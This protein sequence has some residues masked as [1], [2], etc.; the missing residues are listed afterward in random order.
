MLCV[1]IVEHMFE[2]F[3]G[4]SG[5]VS[6]HIVHAVLVAHVQQYMA[7]LD[8]SS[9]HQ[10]VQPPSLERVQNICQNVG[11]HASP[12][13]LT[14]RCKTQEALQTVG[15]NDGLGDAVGVL[16]G[17]EKPTDEAS[18]CRKKADCLVGSVGEEKVEGMKGFWGGR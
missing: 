4:P 18:Y 13:L 2:Y 14:A 9:L 17:G 1:I 16:D 12:V 15:Q 11:S 5:Q 8:Q 7:A 3:L 6:S 10:G